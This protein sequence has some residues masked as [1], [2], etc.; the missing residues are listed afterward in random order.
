M[1]CVNLKNQLFLTM[2]IYISNII[3]ILFC[4]SLFLISPKSFTQPVLNY[5]PVITGLNSPVDIVNAS[6]G[7]NRV[8]IVQQTGMIKIYDQ[9][10]SYVGD[11]LTVTGIATS[12]ER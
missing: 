11:F 6:D 3:A 9:S 8:F 4:F 1:N 10:L 12:G 2:K 5:K 7:S